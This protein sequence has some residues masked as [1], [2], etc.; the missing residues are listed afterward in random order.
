MSR[1]LDPP[2][3]S[4]RAQF[5]YISLLPIL[6]NQVHAKVYVPGAIPLGMVKGNLSGASAFGFSGRLPATP[7]AGQPPSME[8]MTIHLDDLVAGLS[9][10]RAS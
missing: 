4:T 5:M 1:V 6:L 8:W 10:V 9:F 7:L 2:E 3:M